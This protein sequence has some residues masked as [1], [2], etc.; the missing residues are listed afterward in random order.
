M[1]AVKVMNDCWNNGLSSMSLRLW[2]SGKYVIISMFPKVGLFNIMLWHTAGSV[3]DIKFKS[4]DAALLL[5]PGLIMQ[6]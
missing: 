3:S 2:S 5:M 1:T 4:K 6:I